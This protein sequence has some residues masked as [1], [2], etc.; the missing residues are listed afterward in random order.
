[1]ST[2]TGSAAAALT[3]L[4]PVLMPLAVQMGIPAPLAAA[5]IA[6]GSVF[7]DNIAPISDTTVASTYSVGADLSKAVKTRFKYS[8]AA[9]V[10]CA[11]IFLVLGFI[12]KTDVGAASE[13][14]GTGLKG[15]V[16]L[17]LPVLLLVLFLKKVNFLAALLLGCL[18]GIIMLLVMGY[19]D[20]AMLFSAEGVIITGIEGM[21]NIIIFMMFIFIVLS[22]I[23][24][25]GALNK[26]ISFFGKFAKS[27]RSA[28]AM[29]GIFICVTVVATASGVSSMGFCGPIIS[30]VLTPFGIAKERMSNLLDGLGCAVVNMLPYA[31]P[32]L[33][34][35]ALSVG[36]G[37]VSENFSV[38]DY[39]PYN[40]FPMALFLVY[41]IAVFT[42]WG[43]KIEKT[44]NVLSDK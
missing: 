2:A 26:L 39:L 41:W 9:A 10:P 12:M 29:S 33:V 36:T 16:F 7:G 23:D 14:A 19:A 25:A 21:L 35:V 13:M 28:E 32:A 17:V 18:L 37:A 4:V 5:A 43:R 31:G 3:T 38:F 1:M 24:E 44:E 27:A 30:K 42:G 15:L 6:S 11:V 22:L 20:V 40:F 34:T 8:M